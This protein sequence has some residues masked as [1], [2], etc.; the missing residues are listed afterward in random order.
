VEGVKLV[1]LVLQTLRAGAAGIVATAV[2]V[3][4]LALLVSGLHSSAHVANV[5]ALVV[6][7]VANFVGNRY[8]AFRARGQL[9]RHAVGYTVVELVAL[10]LNGWLFEIALRLFPHATHAYWA[11][12]LATS[13]IVFLLWSYPLWCVVFKSASPARS[14][15]RIG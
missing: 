10:A 13:H 9:A 4:T 2:D 3:G 14:P 7:G 5:P 1:P 11:L 6:G 12:R 8:F 15:R